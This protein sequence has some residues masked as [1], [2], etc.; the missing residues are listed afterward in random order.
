MGSLYATVTVDWE[1]EQITPLSLQALEYFKT[2]HPDIP[3]THFICPAYFTRG[4]DNA[5]YE[6]PY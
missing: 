5:E 2:V 1:G 3:L 6:K 4:Q